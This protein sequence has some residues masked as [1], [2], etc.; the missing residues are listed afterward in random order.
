MATVW[1]GPVEVKQNEDAIISFGFASGAFDANPQ[2]ATPFLFPGTY[3]QFS[4]N[5]TSDPASTLLFT[6]NST[7]GAIIFSTAVVNGTTYGVYTFTIPHS[8]TVN[9]PAGEFYYGL[10]WVQGG[11][12]AIMQDGP[13]IVSPS[14]PR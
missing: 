11:S 13:F 4:A 7:S 1:S 6:C 12:N 2:L 10:L 8:V 9:L 5:Q 14:N 3:L